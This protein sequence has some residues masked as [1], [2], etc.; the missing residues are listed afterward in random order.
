MHVRKHA[1]MYVGMHVYM[2][3]F[4][5]SNIYMYIYIY[6]C[7]YIYIYVYGRMHNCVGG[8]YTYRLPQAVLR[9]DSL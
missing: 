3:V 9:Q 4:L 6:I 8:V 5:C 2:Y 7:I 1:C